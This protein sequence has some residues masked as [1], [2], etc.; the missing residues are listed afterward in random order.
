MRTLHV[1]SPTSWSLPPTAAPFTVPL[2][3]DA[4]PGNLIL[5]AASDC[6]NG[7]GIIFTV[8][9][10]GG[11]PIVSP[12][13]TDGTYVVP[14]PAGTVLIDVAVATGCNAGPCPTTGT[15]TG[16]SYPP[17]GGGYYNYSEYDFSGDETF[18]LPANA[19]AGN[20]YLQIASD[21]TPDGGNFVI[22]IDGVQVLDS[23]CQSDYMNT[24]PIPMN[25][26]TVRIVGTIG[27]TSSDPSGTATV[28]SFQMYNNP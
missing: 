13:L 4:D 23:G 20:L 11:V 9:L 28:L 12:C 10:D 25:T 8:T 5:T 14:I 24:V 15:G 3:P 6:E 18:V 7:E 21:F 19:L 16:V 17:G 27:C 1:P 2:P 22:Y 26:A